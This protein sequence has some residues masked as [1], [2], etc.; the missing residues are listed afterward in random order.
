MKITRGS[1][2]G[3]TRDASSEL[4]TSAS[5]AL[6]DKLSHSGGVADEG[7]S[8]KSA[9]GGSG[10][11]I[12]VVIPARNEAQ[13]ISATVASARSLPLVDLV[14]VVDDG[15]HDLTA[16]LAEDAGA[17]V[18]SYRRGRGKAAAMETG[19]DVVSSR[20]GSQSGNDAASHCALLFLD[21]DLEDSAGL[22][23]P[24]I[25]P[26]VAGTADMT[27]ATLPPAEAPGGGRGRV[28]RLSR[29]GILRTTGFAPSQ[30]LSGQRCMSLANLARLR[31]LAK[32][33]G[34]ETGLTIDA[35]RLGLRVIEI[36]VPLRHRV[37]G[38]GAGDR[39]H[40]VQQFAD[41]AR[42][43]LPRYLSRPLTG[44]SPVVG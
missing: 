27:I 25:A 43:L 33:F 19:A 2:S 17:L 29:R 13:R 39:L 14:V 38:T 20:D 34:V 35:L 22:A 8:V 9:T 36:D 24:L 31:P 32:G 26:I 1:R 10:A 3:L 40:R 5:Y 37:T 44:K 21:A 30:P 41:V 16:K 42:A 18:V 4:T 28:V 7:C 6:P 12:S 23:G 11:R 15:S